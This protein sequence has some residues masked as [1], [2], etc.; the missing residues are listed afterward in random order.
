[1]INILKGLSHKQ[2]IDNVIYLI[3]P[4]INKAL[5]EIVRVRGFLDANREEKRFYGKS[6]HRGR[7]S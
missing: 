1:M 5:V 4:K 6:E 7:Y 2:K 3:T